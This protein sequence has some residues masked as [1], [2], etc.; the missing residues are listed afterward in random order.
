MYLN[1]EI[2][3]VFCIEA[4]TGYNTLVKVYVLRKIIYGLKQSAQQWSKDLANSMR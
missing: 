2:D 4:S 3:V 1:S